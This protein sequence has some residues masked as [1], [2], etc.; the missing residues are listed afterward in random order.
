VVGEVVAAS[1]AADS[2]V[3]DFIVGSSEGERKLA[4]EGVALSD[5]ERAFL[6]ATPHHHHMYQS[7]HSTQHILRVTAIQCWSRDE[8]RYTTGQ[9]SRRHV[10][11]ER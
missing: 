11:M 6:P 2:A 10:K 7:I 4:R 8:E 3:L 5:Q 1:L 9:R